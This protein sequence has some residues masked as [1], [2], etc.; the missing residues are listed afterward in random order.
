MVPGETVLSSEDHEC[1]KKISWQ[2][3]KIKNTN[4]NLVVVLNEEGQ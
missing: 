1:L 3:I 2:T 4:M